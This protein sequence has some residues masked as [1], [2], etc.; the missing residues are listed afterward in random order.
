MWKLAIF[1]PLFFGAYIVLFVSSSANAKSSCVVRYIE[2]AVGNSYRVADMKPLSKG[3]I[4]RLKKAG[5]D[6]EVEK[7]D[8][9]MDAR[10]DVWADPDGWLYGVRKGGQGDVEPTP[11]WLNTNEI[12][13]P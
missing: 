4:R 9:G 1:T 5:V 13:N 12:L 11:L 2:N 6:P 8:I 10:F 7:S 3:M